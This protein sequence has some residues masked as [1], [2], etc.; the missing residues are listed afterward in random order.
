M[1]EIINSMF[2]DS[3]SETE[4]ED[5]AKDSHN[6]LNIV[7]SETKEQE[8]FHCILNMMNDYNM[9]HKSNKYLKQDELDKVYT[10]NERSGYQHSNRIFLSYF[11]DFNPK[12][13]DYSIIFKYLRNVKHL[14][15]R[16]FINCVLIKKIKIP[17][18]VTRLKFGV[19]IECN[20]LK[21]ITLPDSL[22]IN[23]IN[24]FADCYSLK[25][26]KLPKNIKKIPDGTFKYCKNLK[27]INIPNSVK[28]LGTLCFTNC[29]NAEII[30]IPKS[31][32][33]IGSFCFNENNKVKTI[34]IPE[35][36]KD[37]LKSM[38]G[39]TKDLSK[40]KITYI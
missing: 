8:L 14:N 37:D 27:I 17:K 13:G 5:S 34:T 22:K 21:S 1:P 10:I 40:V 16:C 19:F 32:K 24:C 7:L 11:K 9:P 23:H 15:D 25:S 6:E 35:K 38:F 33:T 18:T 12:D 20:N 3:E 30:K 26:I 36:F 31:V 28:K 2:D 4:I 39:Y 29:E